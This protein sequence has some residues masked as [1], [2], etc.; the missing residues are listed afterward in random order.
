MSES[1]AIKKH[2]YP[3]RMENPNKRRPNTSTAARSSTPKED[4][5]LVR[6]PI[7]AKKRAT[8]MFKAKNEIER[9]A[10]GNDEVDEIGYESDEIKSID[11]N[12]IDDI[13]DKDYDEIILDQTLLDK[14]RDTIGNILKEVRNHK[15]S[16]AEMSKKDPNY[17]ASELKVS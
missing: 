1:P 11:D 16:V 14:K 8:Q 10:Y 3:L 4:N 2:V 6:R 15:K 5:S 9:W 7:T 13:V 17:I 12:Y